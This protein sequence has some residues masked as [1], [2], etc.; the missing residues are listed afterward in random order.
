[1]GPRSYERGI[2]PRCNMATHIPQCFNGAAFLRTRNQYEG[3]GCRGAFY[4]LQ[5]GRVLTNAES[6]LYVDQ[7]ALTLVLQWGRVLTNAE[8]TQ[9]ASDFGW[10]L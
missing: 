8:S 2:Y 3:V 10:W 4:R 1:M 6:D 9:T 5:W 7:V